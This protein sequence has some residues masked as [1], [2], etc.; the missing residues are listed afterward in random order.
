MASASTGPAAQTEVSTEAPA[1]MSISGCA[2]KV[3]YMQ[4]T[5]TIRSANASRVL[6]RPQRRL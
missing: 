3:A 4:P 5:V 6:R 1:R 2:H